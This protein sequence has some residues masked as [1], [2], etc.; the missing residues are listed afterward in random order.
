MGGSTLPRAA[1]NEINTHIF[2]LILEPIDR[3]LCRDDWSCVV[4]WAVA[5]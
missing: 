3:E 2:L 5:G 4:E 1:T